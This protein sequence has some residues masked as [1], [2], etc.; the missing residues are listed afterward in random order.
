MYKY[1]L[2]VIS[3]FF[4]S[5][6]FSQKNSEPF[7]KENK[8]SLFDN[9]LKSLMS[10]NLA[11]FENN[12]TFYYKSALKRDY[13]GR[14]FEFNNKNVHLNLESGYLITDVSNSNPKYFKGSVV[15]QLL[16][17][18]L[19]LAF[20]GQIMNLNTGE[21]LITH[22]EKNNILTEIKNPKQITW[23]KGILKTD[24][25]MQDFDQLSRGQGKH[26]LYNLLS[27]SIF[28]NS[29]DS[30]RLFWGDVLNNPHSKYIM[31]K[32]NY[33]VENA[34]PGINSSVYCLMG[35]YNVNDKIEV[36][37]FGVYFYPEGIEPI[38]YNDSMI[39]YS[40]PI[41]RSYK[42]LNFN[43]NENLNVDLSDEN[44]EDS[45]SDE[46]LSE[47]FEKLKGK[48]YSSKD[49]FVETAYFHKKY[50]K[51]DISNKNFESHE[52]LYNTYKNLLGYSPYLIVEYNFREKQVKSIIDKPILPLKEI[53]AMYIDHN[54]QFLITQQQ[55]K[56]N[57]QFTIF[58]LRTKKEIITLD[59]IISGINYKNELIINVL[60]SFTK[61]SNPPYN[62]NP[63][64]AS[65]EMTKLNL[66]ELTKLSD[67]YFVSDFDSSLN[68]DEFITKEVFNSKISFKIDKINSI[69][70]KTEIVNKKTKK[71]ANT[72]DLYSNEY[73]GS[74]LE[75]TINDYRNILD[76]AANKNDLKYRISYVS[77]SMEDKVIEFRFDEIEDRA[78]DLLLNF[79]TKDKFEIITSGQYLL[80]RFN[81]VSIEDAKK[82]KDDNCFIIAKNER[83]KIFKIPNITNLFVFKNFKTIK[84]HFSNMT[85]SEKFYNLFVPINTEINNYYNSLYFKSNNMDILLYQK[86]N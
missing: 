3:S 6:T 46:P 54:N 49:D 80:I 28:V 69:T 50:N 78:R 25:L 15:P 58:N 10:N 13:T 8:Y 60:A 86:E 39:Y 16:N 27:D 79:R 76:S 21:F 38:M 32:T 22:N 40:V 42:F 43:F 56:Q 85:D 44:F 18:T 36:P 45:N 23:A 84:R 68:V 14:Y 66:N 52:N 34:K 74:Y 48:A 70:P 9:K 37:Q 53:S 17:D 81:N 51:L 41:G 35:R 26:F 72:F 77:Y 31:H 83:P 12:K 5:V 2:F 62:L 59:G 82:F 4:C 30:D 7:I 57:K 19:V 65:I 20:D 71:T 63:I 11:T 24:I 29:D 1:I 73:I 33:S 67:E 64:P 47:F 75:N 61:N 55:N